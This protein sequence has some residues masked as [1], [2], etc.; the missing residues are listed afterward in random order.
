MRVLHVNK[1]GSKVGG[2]EGYIADVA[3]ALEKEGHRSHL[4]YFLQGDSGMPISNTTQVPLDD[5]PVSTAQAHQA[6]LRVI[7]EFQPDVVYLHVVEH[8][9]LIRWFAQRLPTIA[10]VHGP[11]PVCPGSALYLRNRAQVCPHK[12]GLICLVNAQ[13]E[14]CCWGRNPLEHWR[15]LSR[16]GAFVEAYGH[17]DKILVGSHFMQQ[18]LQQGGFSPEKLALLSPVLIDGGTPPSNFVADTQTI[19]F[20]GR[21]VP[22]KGLHSLLEALAR[23]ETNWQLVVAGDGPERDRCQVQAA[24]LGIAERVHFTGWLDGRQVA[25]YLEASVCVAIP[26]LWPEPYGRV[27]PEAFLHAR[28]AVAFAVGGIPD[29][30][31]DGVTGYLVPPGD[32]V[33]LGQSLRTLLESPDLRWHMGQAARQK[34]L[35]SW[36]ARDHVERLLSV[37][38]AGRAAHT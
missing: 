31:E 7:S 10:Y 6:L 37:F 34:A 25:T 21:L 38:E 5:W 3:R 28:P 24:Q 33:K 12:A 32:T 29:W 4:V 27:G 15:L 1:F 16:V 8:P 26:S 9:D 17:V 18:L 20:A 2:A 11:Y 14:R 35:A 13:L 19:L 22:E 30:L 23:I 36:N